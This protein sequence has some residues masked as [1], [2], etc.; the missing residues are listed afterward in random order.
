MCKF[1]H[2]S[3]DFAL[4]KHLFINNDR[5]SYSLPNGSILFYPLSKIDEKG[6][7]I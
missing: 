5:K 4:A 6:N 2:F 7:Y 1:I 3:L